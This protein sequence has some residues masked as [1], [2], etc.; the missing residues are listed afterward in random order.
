[1]PKKKSPERPIEQM[2]SAELMRAYSKRLGPIPFGV[3]RSLS[4][5]WNPNLLIRKQLEEAIRSG[6]PVK[7]WQGWDPDAE[8]LAGILP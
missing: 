2:N 5:P 4:S 6:T 7:E 1:M 8:R 3:R